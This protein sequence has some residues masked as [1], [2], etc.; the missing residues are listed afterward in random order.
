MAFQK[1]RMD[2]KWVI[3]IL[4]FFMEFICLGF[5]S[6]NVG[7]YTKAVTEALHIKRSAYSLTIS[8]R[9][10]VQVLASLNFGTMVN[11]FG[12]KKMACAG[13]L[14]LA[15]SVAIRAWATQV[16]HIYI[17]G[18]LWGLGMVFAGGTMAGTI[19]QRWFHQDVGRYTGIV[20]SANGIGG[21]LAA[22]IISPLINNGEVFGYRKAYLLSAAF[23]LAI[24][25]LIV[26]FLHES[27][28]DAPEPGNIGKKKG[29]K[30]VLWKGIPYETAKKK[31]YFY[32]AA[33]LVFI[34]GIGLQSIGSVTLV[35]MADMGM[36]PAFIAATATVHSL[37]LAFSKVFVGTTYDKRG[38]Q[39]TLLC[40][41][42]AAMLSY[43]MFAILTNSAVG[44]VIAMIA[45]VLETLAIPMETV[46][47]P[48]LSNDL[49]GSASYYKVLGIFMAMNSLGLCLGS[50]LGDLC[51]DILGTYKPCFWF[52]SVLMAVVAISYH[53]V[54]RAAYRDKNAILA[55]GNVS[56]EP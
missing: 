6:S 18:V 17:G 16:F 34:T 22:Q 30:G 50:P 20:M 7:L 32:L 35:Y 44:P 25:I 51:F 46:I 41:Q 9:Y 28:V 5:C 12:A 11:R 13:M 29:P 1:K 42:L 45:V 43:I 10:A 26:L 24:S 40:C 47:I 37:C 31:P 53:F 19:I 33:I 49:F 39:I 4:C 23:T 48:L 2:Y 38:L 14:S 54:I 15:A 3:L 36:T 27:P 52:F 8:I 21:A 56:N 55:E